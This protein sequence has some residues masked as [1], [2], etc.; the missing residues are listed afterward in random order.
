[1]DKDE[2][3]IDNHQ[4]F[5][6]KPYLPPHP[7]NFLRPRNH[8]LHEQPPRKKHWWLYF[9]LLII[10]VVGVNCGVRHY[11]LSD[12]PDDP[13]VYDPITLKPR[14]VGFLQTVKNYIFKSENVLDGEATDRINILLLGMGGVGHDGPY[15]TDTNIIV[16]IK[17][18]TKQIAMISVPRDLGVKIDGH[19]INKINYA[20]AYGEAQATG[21]GGELARETFADTFNLDI[22]Y[23]IR[24]DFQ[25][26]ED[27]IN[28]VGG[29]TIDVPRAFSDN[30]FP[31]ENNSY[32]PISFVAGIQTMSGQRAL[33]YARSRHGNNGEGSDFARS[34][35]QQQVISALKDRLLSFGTYT[36][37]VK[38]Q[39][40]LNT[41]SSHIITNLN[42]GQIMYLAGLA[43]EMN[44]NFKTLVLDN[45]PDGFLYSYFGQNGAFLLGPKNENFN[46]INLA[47]KNVFTENNSQTVATTDSVIST[48]ANQSVFSTAKI[49]LQNGTWRVGLAAKYQAQLEAQGFTIATIGNSSKR[50]LEKTAIYIINQT[51]ATEIINNLEKELGIKSTATLPDWLMEAYD[52]PDTANIEIGLKYRPDTDIL[53]ILGEDKQ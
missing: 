4:D 25:A 41:L 40:M 48:P 14:R 27:L 19:G 6:G 34:K 30:E 18:S 35:R 22:P 21:T 13:T 31:G 9:I 8:H 37:P 33:E 38:V 36:N 45:S 43:R 11:S 50:P 24:V 17:P 3:I 44:N 2:E 39:E 28:A 12:M 20:N 42:F 15:L 46:N 16:S 5:P 32:R 1:M 47:I 29:I 26:F 10:L 49:E 52:Y 53:V 51:A 23:Y 7:T